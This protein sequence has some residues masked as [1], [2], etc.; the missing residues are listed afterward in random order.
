[1]IVKTFKGQ[2]FVFL[3]G[4]HYLSSGNTSVLHRIGGPA[5]IWDFN[6]KE[7]WIHGKMVTKEEHDFLYDLLSLKGLL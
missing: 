7:Y 2:N 6:I 4:I 5:R 3:R 1:M